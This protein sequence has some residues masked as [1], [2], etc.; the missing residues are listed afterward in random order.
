MPLV[1]KRIVITRARSQT[2]EL[3]QLI[4]EQ[5][6]ET[7]EFPVIRL[8]PV[9]DT[10]ELDD[11][12]GRI[13]EFD[14]I[15]WT[16][17]NGVEFL[18]QRARELGVDLTEI[19]KVKIA[20]VGAKTAHAL[21]S[22]GLQADVVP[23]VYHA[24]AL[25]LALEGRVNPGERVLFPK[26][27]IARTVLP[28]GLRKLGLSV[29]E[30]VVY[31]NVISEEGVHEVLQLLGARQIDYITFTSSSTVTNL[32]QVLNHHSSESAEDLLQN[33]SLVYIGPQTAKTA[34]DLGLQIDIMAS[35]STLS[36]LVEAILEHSGKATT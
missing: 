3:I 19:Q 14:W 32:V 22:A 31:R 23:D 36:G 29:T 20:A 27:D 10:R 8:T 17:V 18:L 6:G 16:S 12:L 15:V 7:I 5:G 13:H 2:S 28:D 30:L 1:G 24:E 33:V 21:G 35:T 25:I 9:E 11:V 34:L 4:Q 26:A